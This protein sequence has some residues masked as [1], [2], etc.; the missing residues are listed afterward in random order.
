MSGRETIWSPTTPLRHMP[1]LDGLRAVAAGMV[2]CFHFYRPVREYVHLGGIGVRVF[3]AL[4]GFLITGIL[5]RTRLA[6]DAGSGT[7]AVALRRFYIRRVLRIFPL[8]YFALALA[9]ITRVDGAREGI[10]WHAA[11]L[12]NVLFYLENAAHPGH[13]GGH[14]SHFWSLAVEEQFYLLWPWV[15]FFAPRHRLPAIALSVAALGP[16]FRFL[17]GTATGND[18]TPV[19]L[20]GCIDSLALGAYLAM[21][22]LPEFETHPLIR[23]IGATV[24]WSGI[25]L[26][27]A[28]L[29]A[30]RSG[31][32]WAFRLVSFDLAIA[33]TGVWLVAKAARGIAGPVGRLLSSPP[34]RYLGTISYGIYVYHLL[35]PDLLPRVARRL[36][37]PDLLAPLGDQTLPFLA[38]YGGASVLVAAVSWHAFEAPINRLKDRFEYR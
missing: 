8:Y 12:S 26:F 30:E 33:L 2:V 34:V 21:G 28:Y 14:V 35:L 36:G 25:A 4:S 6:T 9:W 15:I 37:H 7:S 19:L 11:Y 27:A 16:V 22:V 20:P 17:V 23:P 32:W 5:L 31:I 38:F 3:F 29:L 13:W 24:L 18:I 1:Q 10:A